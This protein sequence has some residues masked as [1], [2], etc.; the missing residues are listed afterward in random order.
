MTPLQSSIRSRFDALWEG[1][2]AARLRSSTEA[3]ALEAQL[4]AQQWSYQTRISR[5]KKHGTEFVVVL[6]EH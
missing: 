3:M 4:R 2:P 1:V 6:L 5:T